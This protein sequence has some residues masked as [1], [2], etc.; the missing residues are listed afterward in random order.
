MR[1][2]QSRLAVLQRRRLRKARAPVVVAAWALAG[3]TAS[4]LSDLRHEEVVELL[5]N[6][7]TRTAA[8]GS[9]QSI[10]AEFGDA[11]DMMVILGWEIDNEPGLLIRS[12]AIARSS[13]SLR[14][15]YPDGFVA[16]DQP[17]TRALIVDFDDDDFHADHVRLVAGG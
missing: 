1:P 17:A 5:R 16:A 15:I 12:D 6:S 10:V 3:V 9:M 2:D 14:T 11:G 13:A 8:V 7:G 4:V